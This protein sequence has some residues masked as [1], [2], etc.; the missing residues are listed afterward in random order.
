MP[1]VL[2]TSKSPY[3]WEVDAGGTRA[4]IAI[5]CN[6]AGTEFYVS[7]QP[8]G[9]AVTSV[10]PDGQEAGA[11]EEAIRAYE[12]AGHPRL[13]WDEI[14]RE[15]R[16][17]GAFGRSITTEHGAPGPTE[18]YT[19]A[20]GG[21]TFVVHWDG[22]NDGDTIHLHT[23]KWSSGEPIDDSARARIHA[24]F[25]AETEGPLVDT[26]FQPARRLR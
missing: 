3:A 12:A 19:Y 7:I 1:S 24:A 25:L 21:R 26:F 11:L 8:F 22:R 20:E 17:R 9:V 16:A 23:T 18:V 15:L 5:Q 6:N 14:K 10:M 2:V 4:V 13:P